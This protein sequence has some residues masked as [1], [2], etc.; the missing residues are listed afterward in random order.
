MLNFAGN[1]VPA[2]SKSPAGVP[3]QSKS[4]NCVSVV[5]TD[6]ATSKAA[7][8]CSDCKSLRLWR[9]SMKVIDSSGSDFKPLVILSIPMHC[10]S[11]AAFAHATASSLPCL[12]LCLRA[13]CEAC[14]LEISAATR[15]SAFKHVN[16]NAILSSCSLSSVVCL[17]M[18]AFCIASSTSVGNQSFP[19]FST[20]IGS[21]SISRALASANSLASSAVFS[22]MCF[23]F[24]SVASATDRSCCSFC[25]NSSAIFSAAT[26]NGQGAS[27]AFFSVAMRSSSASFAAFSAANVCVSDSCSFSRT[28]LSAA[29]RSSSAFAAA[30]AAN[31]FSSAFLAAAM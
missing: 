14:F 16:K 22:T 1:C 11:A 17:S 28:L 19:S 29:M 4:T 13:A 2:E 7:A 18:L 23:I 25:F 31:H 26:I 8:V 6:D 27:H 20:A 30:S 9:P 10:A 12:D 5:S 15:S 24:S 21:R 3:A